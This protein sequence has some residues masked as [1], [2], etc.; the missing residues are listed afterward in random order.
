MRLAQAV[1]VAVAL[2]LLAS[3]ET[4]NPVGPIKVQNSRNPFGV[5]DVLDPDGRDVQT[6]AAGVVLPGDAKDPNAEQ[7]VKVP[8][9]GK[10]GSIEGDW[11]GRWN[12]SEGPWFA[13]KGACQ[14]QEVG[15]R[16]YI[17]VNA[18]APTGA[19][20]YWLIDLK[21]NKDRL[22]GRGH[23]V[24]TPAPITNLCV[25]QVVADERIDGRWQGTDQKKDTGR[26]DFRRRL[27]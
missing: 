1:V 20:A 4:V 15:G 24:D 7:W 6:F 22:V 21:R 27:K 3:C 25:F 23:R 12:K 16:V 9:A 11:S 5:P 13:A 10:K 14:I 2:V 19:D 26:W 8:T 17:F 18:T